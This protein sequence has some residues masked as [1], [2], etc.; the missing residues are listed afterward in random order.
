MV[1]TSE[2]HASSGAG[3][4]MH[5]HT[6]CGCSGREERPRLAESLTAFSAVGR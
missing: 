3:N 4:L 2:D 1:V 5:K 6:V